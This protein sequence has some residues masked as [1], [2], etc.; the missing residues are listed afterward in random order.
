[1][2]SCCMTVHLVGQKLYYWIQYCQIW[3]LEGEHL[4]QYGLKYLFGQ[5]CCEKG[6]HQVCH[7]PLK[8]RMWL[9]CA[10]AGNY[11]CWPKE[12]LDQDQLQWS[13]WSTQVSSFIKKITSMT[14][15]CD[16]NHFS[17]HSWS[18]GFWSNI[19][20]CQNVLI[21]LVRSKKNVSLFRQNQKQ[22]QTVYKDLVLDKSVAL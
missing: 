21:T 6:E 4:I 8:H 16:K 19:E 7:L 3:V 5:V 11:I 15:H 17:D 2:Q 1:M 20:L 18:S 10:V 9:S 13:C 22:N 14:F 12:S